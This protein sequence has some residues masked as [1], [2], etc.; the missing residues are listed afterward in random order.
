MKKLGKYQEI[1]RFYGLSVRKARSLFP[2]NRK[3]NN[4]KVGKRVKKK[5]LQVITYN[6]GDTRL[7]KH[8][9]IKVNGAL[10]K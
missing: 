5:L 2:K 10:K 4:R 8:H 9:N 3:T 6:D 7:I 1:A